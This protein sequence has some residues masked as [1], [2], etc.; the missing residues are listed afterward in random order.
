MF[1]TIKNKFFDFVTCNLYQTA[2][3][4]HQSIDLVPCSFI[5]VGDHYLPRTS[6]PDQF[7]CLCHSSYFVGPNIFSRC[8]PLLRFPTIIP[9]VTRCSSFSL[10]SKWPKNVGLALARFHHSSQNQEHGFSSSCQNTQ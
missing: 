4:F 7:H 9:V 3:R 2:I 5:R 10:L 6:I 1:F 8:F